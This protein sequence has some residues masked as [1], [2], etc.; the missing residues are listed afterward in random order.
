MTDI[1]RR[2]FSKYQLFS[3][4]EGKIFIERY[5]SLPEIASKLFVFVKKCNE[6]ERRCSSIT[7]RFQRTT[8]N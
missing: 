1:Y 5:A 4:K 2:A 3:I 8:C 7:M 6:I